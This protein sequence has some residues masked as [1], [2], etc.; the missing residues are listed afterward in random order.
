M[1]HIENHGINCEQDTFVVVDI[2]R[3]HMVAVFVDKL[4]KKLKEK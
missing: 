3:M 2:L 4:L 1:D